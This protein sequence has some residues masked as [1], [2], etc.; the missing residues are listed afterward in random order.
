[1]YL[2]GTKLSRMQKFLEIQIIDTTIHFGDS[3]MVIKLTSD[4]ISRTIQY[5]MLLL[6][7]QVVF[8]FVSK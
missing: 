6:V 3:Y 7:H 4:V 1:M 2:D 5:S 8:D